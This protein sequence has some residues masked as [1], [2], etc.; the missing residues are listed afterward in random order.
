M[1]CPFYCC[2]ALCN[3]TGKAGYYADID[4]TATV[5]SLVLVSICA[6]N[7]TIQ[8]NMLDLCDTWDVKHT[9]CRYEWWGETAPDDDG[10]PH[11]I[12][13][14]TAYLVLG[15]LSVWGFFVLAM[16]CAMYHRTYAIF[17]VIAWIWLSVNDGLTLYELNKSYESCD[18]TFVNDD[19]LTSR[20]QKRWNVRWYQLILL[21]W[22]QT[23]IMLNTVY[24]AYT[25]HDQRTN[26]EVEL[27]MKK[28]RVPDSHK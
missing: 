26:H 14:M 1:C 10:T 15:V 27:E 11:V 13:V 21:S 8:Y 18:E 3:Q 22:L 6:I 7:F 16:G 2:R 9:V 12:N 25:R 28:R 5:R 4:W 19:N 17:L 23:I 20:C 24:D